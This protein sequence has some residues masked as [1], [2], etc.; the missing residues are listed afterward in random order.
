MMQL[1]HL[2]CCGSDHV[3][4]HSGPARTAFVER[5]MKLVLAAA[6]RFIGAVKRNRNTRLLE[7]VSA[8][9][10]GLIRG[11]DRFNVDAVN[12]Q[13]RPLRFST[14]GMWWIQSTIRE[15]LN[16]YDVKV[17]RHRSYHDQFRQARAELLL[18]TGEID[19]DDTVV[20]RFLLDERGWTETK[21]SKFIDDRDR[22]LVPMESVAE[23]SATPDF[24][25]SNQ[26]RVDDEP[27]DAAIGIERSELLRAA[28]NQLPFN[29]MFMVMQHYFGDE[30]YE[31]IAKTFGISHERVRQIEND[32]LRQLWL[33]LSRHRE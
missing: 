1:I 21:L 30:T 4:D 18:K 27:I 33:I 11:I 28:I 29:Q 13:G 14:Y 10:V 7:L 31:D 8:G 32:A 12:A 17:I 19:L 5:N 9:T 2:N 25:E 20:Y 15:E 16:Q 23:Q 24:L 22:R 26:F 6:R 3:A